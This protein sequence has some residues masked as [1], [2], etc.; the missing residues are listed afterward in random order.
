M[1]H[2]KLFSTPNPRHGQQLAHV[3][4]WRRQQAITIK[5]LW[6]EGVALKEICRRVQVTEDWVDHVIRGNICRDVGAPTPPR[7]AFGRNGKARLRELVEV[8]G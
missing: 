7:K 3:R 2:P 5:K 6:N 8:P 4:A 1:T